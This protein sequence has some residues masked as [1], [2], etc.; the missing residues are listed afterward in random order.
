[1]RGF[2]AGGVAAVFETIHKIVSESIGMFAVL[3]SPMRGT[4]GHSITLMAL[5]ALVIAAVTAVRRRMPVTLLF[6]CGYL[7]IVVVWPYAPSRFL[8]AIWPVFLLLFA[9]GANWAWRGIAVSDRRA[10]VGRRALLGAFVWVLVGYSEYELR[11]IRGKWWS[12][13]SR[14]SAARIAAAVTWVHDNTSA[15]ELVAS[16]D[17]GAVFLYTGRHT[18]PERS[19]APDAY[20]RDIPPTEAARDGL[21]PILAAYPVNVVVAGS[22]ETA[23]TADILVASTPALLEPAV[24]FPGGVAYRVRANGRPTR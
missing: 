18:V 1:M 14:S 10:V 17:E 19:L 15:G 3:F 22:R 12:T 7:A 8:W 23:E 5:V 2:R 24:N 20:L 4:L 11:G 13:I 16:E 6:L 21:V 9:A